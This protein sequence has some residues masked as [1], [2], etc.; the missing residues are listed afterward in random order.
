MA[1]ICAEFQVS[2][3]TGYK[4]VRRFLQEGDESLAD[5]SHAPH[6]IPHRMPEAIAAY[7]LSL[8]RQH[9]TWGPR[10]LVAYAAAHEATR[11]WPAPSSVGALLKQAGMVRQ[12]RFR[13]AGRV[14]N[15]GGPTAAG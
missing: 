13:K 8:R 4:W 10:K 14:G 1:Q 15:A 6:T 5:R 2:E 9:P 7:F 12:R 11:Q 3:K